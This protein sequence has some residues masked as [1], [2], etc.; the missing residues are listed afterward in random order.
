M[1]RIL[2]STAIIL[3]M[4]AAIGCHIL[5]LNHFADQLDR[6][7][8]QAEKE[9]EREDWSQ[10]EALTRQALEDWE[11]HDFYLHTVM[12]HEDIDDILISFHEALAFLSGAELQPAE[13]AAVNA[14]LLSQLSLLLEEELPTLKNLL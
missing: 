10:A 3:A 13:Y 9:V 8:T 2:I 11:N 12:R 1:K 5:Y 6:L 4:A 7:L 14:R